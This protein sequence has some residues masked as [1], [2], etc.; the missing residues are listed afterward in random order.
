MRKT[1]VV[2]ACLAAGAWWAWTPAARAASEGFSL[3][4]DPAVMETLWTDVDTNSAKFD[5]YRDLRSGFRLE[6]LHIFGEGD[7][8]NR[9]LDV[10]LQNV[11]RRDARYDLR[12]GVSG[13]YRLTIDY[14]KIPHNFG[15][16]GHTLYSRTG[17]GTYEIADPTQLA[18]QN[19][20][21][22]QF[23]I[24]PAGINYTFL[25][26]LLTPYLAAA[27]AVS[28]GLER[29]RMSAR[30]DLGQMGRLAW[31]LQY[32]HENREGTRQYGGSFGFGNATELLEPIDYRT[33]TATLGGEWKGQ[34]GGMSFGYS[35]SKF[36]NKISTMYWDNPFRAVSS[37]DP[38][39]YT[40][41]GAGSI[42]GS[43]IGFADLAPDNNSNRLFWNGRAKLGGWWLHGNAG[44]TELRQDDPLLPYTLNSAIRGIAA[45]GSTFD[46]TN[47]ANLPASSADRKV[48]ITDLAADAG[49]RFAQ[50]FGLTLRYKYYDY[51]DRSSEIDFP[52]YVRFH[53]V[54]EQ[55]PV[56][57][58]PFSYKRQNLSGEFTWDFASRSTFL[59]GYTRER[60]DLTNRAVART[61]EDIVRASV[62]TRA[63]E[64]VLL[65]ASYEYGNR[66]FPGSY[67]IELEETNNPLMREVDLAERKYNLWSLEAEFDPTDTLSLS[68]GVN[69]RKDDYKQSMLGL[70][71]DD[72]TRVN[73][74]LDYQIAAGQHLYLF[75]E[76]ADRKQDLAG[77]QSGA[78]PSTNPADG[79]TV[80]FK[81]KNTFG[82]FGWTGK[83]AKAWT[84]DVTARYSKSD[85][86]ADF[87]SPPGGTPDLAF[88]FGNYD[89]YDLTGAGAKVEYAI[90]PHASFGVWYLYEKYTL[91]TF[92][93]QGLA[94]YLPGALLLNANDGDYRA[95]VIG[96]RLRLAM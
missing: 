60:W 82:G 35:Y 87:F 15:N 9:E 50:D 13:K 54:W 2:I 39:A 48:R 61:D 57:T 41:P 12:Y 29:D 40:A 56:A 17:P 79:W 91:D 27:R 36:E 44:V 46:P 20:I 34:S 5:E 85:G 38:S 80:H 25:N 53:A 65:R 31:G 81:E 58:E 32:D 1:L 93:L 37:T 83:F 76:Y 3:H 51:D 75:G 8:G 67:D 11:G 90:T 84:V 4:L 94:N 52:G 62:D 26:N 74:D 88:G 43:A 21:T 45:D 30:F 68:L 16:D 89:D 47:P 72:I 64:N 10:R 55:V 73:A 78:T 14:N 95:N 7:K 59:L 77:R 19:A 70:Q 71:K 96:L 6:K 24:S 69:G 33:N 22:T 92:V 66:T 63:I 49:T 23:G 18:L 86:L 42:G 28:I